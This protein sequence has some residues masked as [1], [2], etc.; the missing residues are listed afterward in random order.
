MEGMLRVV[1]IHHNTIFRESLIHLLSQQQHITGVGST[2]SI[3]EMLGEVEALQPNV[4]I[5]DFASQEHD[6]LEGVRQI[7]RNYPHLKILM[8]GVPEVE[9]D[10][11]ECIEA[12]AAGYVPQ[13][14]S[15]QELF[16]GIVKV[17]VGEA[18]CSAKVAGFLFSRIATEA[19]KREQFQ[20]LDWASLTRREIEILPL[21]E[22]GLS[23]KEIAVA[24]H[25]E[26]QTVKNHVHNILRKLQLEGR[27][28]VAR[29]IR[30]SGILGKPRRA[31]ENGF[32]RHPSI[33]A[34][35]AV[36]PSPEPTASILDVS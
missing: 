3:H 27:R 35:G 21:L 7:H 36:Y 2:L 19:R 22:E 33:A 26:I 13:E 31:R 11:L 17:A 12:G 1:V 30:E 23:N 18:L 10:I 32:R 34:R 14:A 6:S 28:E 15:L 5:L 16:D 24:L 9:A 8:T 20:L 25:I 4:I 29:Y